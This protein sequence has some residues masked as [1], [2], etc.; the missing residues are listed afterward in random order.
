MTEVTGGDLY[1]LWSVANVHLPN[2]AAV[3]TS[4]SSSMGENQGDIRGAFETGSEGPHGSVIYGGPCEAFFSLHNEF[5]HVLATTGQNLLDSASAV[6]KAIEEFVEEDTTAGTEL[7]S[8]LE[9]E[10]YK[11]GPALHDPDDPA[12]NPPE[13]P[14][15]DPDYPEYYDSPGDEEAE[16]PD[17]TEQDI[18]DLV[19]DMPEPPEDEP[20]DGAEENGDN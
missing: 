1:K 12:Q 20:D 5:Q 17:Q 3:Y 16:D 13:D 2:V 18:E 6:S 10:P 7:D 15:G 4:G 9:G 19:S 14:P 8:V 11:G